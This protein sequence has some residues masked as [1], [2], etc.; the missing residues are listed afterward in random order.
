MDTNIVNIKIVSA[1]FEAQFK[2]KL[3]NTDAWLKKT[4]LI[5]KPCVLG[6]LIIGLLLH[7]EH[8]KIKRASHEQ[9]VRSFKH[10]ATD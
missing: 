4:L 3:S 8:C 6:C 1:T 5:K 2:K 7:K 9:N 10:K